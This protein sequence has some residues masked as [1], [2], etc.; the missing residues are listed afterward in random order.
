MKKRWMKKA[1]CV[2]TALALTV[3]GLTA[4]GEDSGS[5]RENNELAK[6]YV[7]QFQEFAI[8]DLGGDYSNLETSFHVGDRIYDLMSVEHYGDQYYT[9][10]CLI[11]YKED[12]SDIQNVKL[13][14][15]K[16]V[17]TEEELAGMQAQSAAEGGDVQD[18]LSSSMPEEEPA[19]D[20]SAGEEDGEDGTDT[21]VTDDAEGTD[22]D[23][24]DDTDGADAEGTEDGGD[25]GDETG[26]GGAADVDGAVNDPMV[27]TP[28]EEDYWENNALRTFAASG[29][30]IYGLR[31]Y[32]YSNYTGASISKNY[33]CCWNLDGAVRWETPMEDLDNQQE[34][35]MWVQAIG[36]ASDGGINIF[37][38]GESQE[39]IQH[40][41]G[42]GE[43]GERKKIADENYDILSSNYMLMAK[44][45]GRFLVIY[46]DVDDWT[47]QFAAEYDPETDTLGESVPVPGSVLYNYNTMSVGKNTDLIYTTNNGVYTYRFGDEEGKKLMDF[48]NSDLNITALRDVVELDETHFIGTFY[49]NYDNAEIKCGLFTYVP[50]EEIP[51]KKVLVLAGLWI[52][53]DVKQRVIEFNRGSEEYRITIKDYSE[54][55]TYEDYQAGQTRMNNDIVS[56]G[57]PD[58][59][60]AQNSLPIENYIA[61]GW[62]AD[63]N[64]FLEKDEELSKE[65]F[66]QNV[67]DAYSVNGKL[68][69]VIPNFTVSTVVGKKSIVGDRT[70]WTMEDMR[71]LA[72]SLP[73]GTQMFADVIRS[74]FMSYAMSYCSND[75]IDMDTGKCSFDSQEFIDLMEYAKTLPEEYEDRYDD[76]YWMNYESQYREGR[77]VLCQTGISRLRDFNYTLNGNFGGDLRYVGFPSGS[78]KG[79]FIM[80]NEAYC[81]SARSKY[82]DGAWEFVRYYLT[83]EY[84]E[85]D[86]N[87]WIPVQKDMF[88][89]MVQEATERPYYLNEDGEKEEY[90]EYFYMNGEQIPLDP[91]TQEQVDEL[92]EYVC[93]VDQPYRDTT[94]VFNIIQ[95]E[96][97]AFFTGQKG[98]SEVADIIQRRAQVYVDENR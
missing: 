53:S 68:Y 64:P 18:L 45:N 61:K 97:D 63:I 56:S 16:T 54:Y 7:Y 83:D 78:G 88:D 67:F 46:S 23:G 14:V 32:D 34:S 89:K 2:G 31:R 75:F 60:V 36:A 50:P 58:I 12:G 43:F 52:N 37:M 57:M 20:E 91:M 8:P 71:K 6:K 24:T 25:A 66:M 15:N 98:A 62:I 85:G 84:Q 27:T 10:Y 9:D 40:V 1:A 80:Y 51:D 59:L 55:N 87:Y 35:W 22:T 90:D 26:D 33:L 69:Y 95:E 42:D 39:F 17:L 79:A 96:I 19:E 11:S 13:A 5:D 77:T 41:S 76:D 47:K 4:C 30:A 44:D 94:D 65:E 3:G 86:D 92:V 48:V 73:E 74:D 49:E 93:S 21:Y 38:V 72:E 70:S 29:D 28:V 82:Q 81:I